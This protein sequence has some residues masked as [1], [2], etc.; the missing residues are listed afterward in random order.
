MD[1]LLHNIMWVVL[2]TVSGVIFLWTS[3]QGDGSGLSPQDAVALINK[4]HG[5]VVDVRDP[6]DFAKG[7]L[8]N[9]RNLPLLG[10]DARLG[11]LDKLRGRPLIVCGEGGEAAKAVAQFK[12]AGFEQAVALS[13]GLAA[14]R[15]A[16]MPV[17][18]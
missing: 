5:V 3:M 11:E 17:E 8:P 15:E 16:G 9:A 6:G 2:A 13:G 1:F 12:K 7:H 14:W 18:K 4:Q 10:L